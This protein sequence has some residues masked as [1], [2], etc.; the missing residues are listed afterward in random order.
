MSKFNIN[1]F[2]KHIDMH[3]PCDLSIDFI[4]KAYDLLEYAENNPW[5]YLEGGTDIE[6]YLHYGYTL[7]L[8]DCKSP[9]ELKHCNLALYHKNTIGTWVIKA[10]T[11]L[12]KDI[13][14]GITRLLGQYL[15]FL[16]ND[17]KI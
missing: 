13:D 10:Q 1:D 5:K 7:K 14:V 4:K 3:D 8:M 11:Y 12:D 9:T 16:K 17:N 2:A 15:K 6:R